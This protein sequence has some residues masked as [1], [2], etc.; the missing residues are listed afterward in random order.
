MNPTSIETLSTFS[1]SCG[2]GSLRLNI[3]EDDGSFGTQRPFDQ[4]FLVIGRS[5]DSDLQLD[6]DLVNSRHCYLQVIGGRVVSIDLD[7]L[8]GVLL[9]GTP[10]RFG[11]VTPA[12]R[13]QI[14]P[15]TLRL[16]G[17]AAG[18]ERGGDGGRGPQLHPLST[19]YARQLPSAALE[20]DGVA[21]HTYGWRMSRALALIGRSTACQVRLMNPSVSKY[22]AAMIRTPLGVWIVDLLSREGI[23]VD[24]AHVRAARLEEGSVCQLGSFTL[25]L[26]RGTMAPAPPRRSDAP[27][28]ATAP[29]PAPAPVTTPLIPQSAN[30]EG[31]Q[32]LL[33]ASTAAESPVAPA[34][35]WLA[36]LAG[37]ESALRPAWNPPEPGLDPSQQA[38]MM[39]A[40][41]LGAMHRDHMSLV[42]DELTEIRRLAEEMHALRVEIGQRPVAALAPIADPRASS[43]PASVAEAVSAEPVCPEPATEAARNEDTVMREP[44]R[45]DVA[46]SGP[47]DPKECLAIASHFLA[48]YERNQEGH[49]ARILRVL[50]GTARDQE[51]G[52]GPLKQAPLG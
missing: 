33:A 25:R 30:S 44:N 52:R 26:C 47:R 8:G 15:V 48:S 11:W 3:L 39:L 41:M 20:I 5:A 38:M 36:N 21:G 18:V 4:P 12:N 40:Q 13:L 49:W 31:R 28:S 35:T 24:G 43:V 7:S 42:K 2:V 32:V 17:Q 37:D 50:T 9:D 27:Q 16:Q 10:Q 29:V 22:H 34:S 45:G 51:P 14:G 19:Q 23:V 1:E 6:R 46:G